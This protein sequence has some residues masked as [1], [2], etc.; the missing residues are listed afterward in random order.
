MGSY[1]QQMIDGLIDRLKV[2]EG[3]KE[4]VYK[5]TLGIDTIGYGFAIKDLVLSEEI[6]EIILKE[7][8]EALIS[9]IENKFDWFVEM[10]PEVQSVIVECCYQL[11]LYGFNKFKKTFAHLKEKEFKHAADEMLDS[12]WA[13]QTPNRA[14]MLAQ[15]VREHG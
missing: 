10:P 14:N 8:V 2:S 15:I 12:L 11:G 5:D 7:K 6:S 9:R 1:L 13:K 3:F 4:S